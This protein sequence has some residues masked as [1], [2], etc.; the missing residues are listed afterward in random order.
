MMSKMDRGG[1]LNKSKI[2]LFHYIPHN[3]Y[4]RYTFSEKPYY[5]SR[6]HWVEIFEVTL[7]RERTLYIIQ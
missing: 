6:G 5:D 2:M 7:K 1:D 4:Y 3:M